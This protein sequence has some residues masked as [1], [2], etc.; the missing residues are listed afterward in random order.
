M[1][2]VPLRHVVEL[3][4]D[5]SGVSQSVPHPP[6]LLMS[7]LMFVSH[8][9]SGSPSQLE[10]PLAQLGAQVPLEQEVVPLGFVHVLKHDPQLLIDVFV[11]VS[12]PLLGCP[13]QSPAPTEQLG[14]H[15]PPLQDVV[16]FALVHWV[17]QALQW[18]ASVER[19]VS[20]P[21][22]L[23]PSQSAKPAAH[24]GAQMPAE[25][26]VV[27]LAFVHWVLQPP[28]L[29]MSVCVLVSHPSMGLLQSAK[30]ALHPG[31]QNPPTQEIVPLAFVH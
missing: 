23:F 22:F 26:D 8:P 24:D 7:V 29:L 28:Q 4:F 31:A 12:H 2:H 18:L 30:P 9:S 20:Q 25:Q 1:L 6:Q 19:F 13:S 11:S 10:K 27:P 5:G 17:L 21:L 16:P 14:M 3:V 15:T